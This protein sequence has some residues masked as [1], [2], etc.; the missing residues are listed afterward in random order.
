MKKLIVW[1]VFLLGGFYFSAK[2]Y[3][4]YSVSR[5]LDK[6]LIM[7]SP[8]ADIDYSGVSS[9]MGGTLSIDNIRVTVNGYRDPIRAE[10]LSLVTPGFWY[11]MDL[12]NIGSNMASDKVPESLG[13]EIIGFESAVDSDLLKMIYKMGQEK[14]SREVELD[15][16]A[17]CTGK[18]GYTPAILQD[19]GYKDL[20]ADL[21]LSYQKNGNNMI[22]DVS[23]SV[24]E[25]YDLNFQLTLDGAMS[26]QAMATGAYR[27]KL[28]DARL[29]YVDQSL[30]ERTSKLCA[31]AG[32][33]NDE[34]IAAKLDAF[35]SMGEDSGIVFDDQITEPYREFLAGKS[36]FVMT[37]RPNE[38]VN[39]SQ[40]S[41]YKP[42]DVPALL[43]L[44]AIAL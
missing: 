32:L 23:T 11:L 21:R 20:V 16:A 29:E 6:M 25:M 14:A 28:V 10:K 15:A 34:V 18:Y 22:V 1:S 33:S 42:S 40:I 30:D 41:L 13:F 37:A 43:N 44:E 12:S 38:P 9:T 27:P 17:E 2:F 3:L 19:L 26:P 8:F 5:D 4:H 31:R 24:Q 39:M 35:A 36:S 7:V